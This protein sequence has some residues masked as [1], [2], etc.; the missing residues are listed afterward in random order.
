MSKKYLLVILFFSA[1]AFGKFELNNHFKLQSKNN[2]SFNPF[3]KVNYKEQG[4]LKLRA[5]SQFRFISKYFETDI[6]PQYNT[7]YK[8]FGNVN[9]SQSEINKDQFILHTGEVK[10]LAGD[11]V[12]SFGRKKIEIL[13]GALVG[14][15][16]WTHWNRSYTSGTLSYSKGFINLSIDYWKSS[17]DNRLFI[18]ELGDDYEVLDGELSWH[19]EYFD[20][21]KIATVFAKKNTN[22]LTYVGFIFKHQMHKFNIF[23]KSIFQQREAG[24]TTSSDHLFEGKVGYAWGR[25]ID[26][27]LELGLGV[28]STKFNPLT[29]KGLSFSGHMLNYFGGSNLKNYSLLYKK[30]FSNKLKAGLVLNHFERYDNTEPIINQLNRGYFLGQDSSTDKNTIGTEGG[31]VS[32]YKF[33]NEF[34]LLSGGYSLFSPGDYFE[35][36]Q[37]ITMNHF[38]WFDVNLFF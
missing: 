14:T 3:F 11:F 2:F 13:E 15:A 25:K 28:A 9:V 18:L 30:R 10:F 24:A 6:T 20:T 7:I 17:Q 1:G 33:L 27:S 23:A 31:I 16:D 34:G 5:R 21:L 26:H 32:E 8:S 35:G 12:L 36:N 19:P 38:L 29:G 22:K 4:S 37:E